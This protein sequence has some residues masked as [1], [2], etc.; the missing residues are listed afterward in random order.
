MPIL[1]KN[2][3]LFSTLLFLSGKTRID[4]NPNLKESGFRME[5]Y[6]LIGDTTNNPL[7]K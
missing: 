4:T 6:P 7:P 5:K 1:L 3:P 2:V